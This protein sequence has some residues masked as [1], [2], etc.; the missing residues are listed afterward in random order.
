M[1]GPRHA[2]VPPEAIASEACSRAFSAVQAALCMLPAAA[3][4]RVRNCG[5]AR[6]PQPTPPVHCKTSVA[7]AACSA[8]HRDCTSP[9]LACWGSQDG[10]G[11]NVSVQR[12]SVGGAHPAHESLACKA[13]EISLDECIPCR[14]CELD[15]DGLAP[16]ITNLCKGERVIELQSL[17]IHECQV[18]IVSA[19]V[20]SSIQASFI[21]SNGSHFCID[22]TG[23]FHHIKS[24]KCYISADCVESRAG[25][26]AVFIAESS[27]RAP[28]R[29]GAMSSRLV[30][31][32]THPA[33]TGSES[34]SKAEARLSALAWALA[35]VLDCGMAGP[36]T[37]IQDAP[38]AIRAV[39]SESV[40]SG[41]SRSVTLASGLWQMVSAR[42]AHSHFVCA[43]SRL[44]PWMAAAAHLAY[45]ACLPQC[46]HFVTHNACE[47]A[48]SPKAPPL[49]CGMGQGRG[50]QQQE[51]AGPPQ[52][53]A[54]ASAARAGGQ[55]PTAASSASA[56]IPGSSGSAVSPFPLAHCAKA[57]PHRFRW[58]CLVAEGSLSPFAVSG[59]VLQASWSALLPPRAPDALA[60]QA[61]APERRKRRES[62]H[63]HLRLMQ[64]NVQSLGS[65]KAIGFVSKGKL[66]EKYLD[67]LFS[68]QGASFIGIQEA[69]TKGQQCRSMCHHFAVTS[70]CDDKCGFGCELWV[71]RTIPLPNGA[72]LSLEPK[73]VVVR[74]YSPRHLY[75]SV[76]CGPVNLDVVVCHGPC[77]YAPKPQIAGFWQGI[78]DLV[79]ESARVPVV[80]FA[81]ANAQVGPTEDHAIGDVSPSRFDFAG[82]CFAQC[83]HAC[84][85]M[86][87][88]TIR[89]FWKGDQTETW[90]SPAGPK[91]RIDYIALNAAD[92]FSDC[93]AWVDV[94]ADVTI[95]SRDHF[96]LIV[97]TCFSS[98]SAPPPTKRR[99]NICDRSALETPDNRKI[100]EAALQKIP[101]APWSSHAQDHHSDLFGCL[102]TIAVGV[103]PVSDKP[104][105]KQWISE[106]TMRVLDVRRSVRKTLRYAHMDAI[107][108]KLA[109]SML[110]WRNST[111]QLHLPQ[112]ER[113][114]KD[115]QL[116]PIV[117]AKRLLDFIQ[118]TMLKRLY[119]SEASIKKAIDNDKAN[120]LC[121]VAANAHKAMVSHDY[122]SLFAIMK[123][124]MPKQKKPVQMLRLPDQSLASTPDEIRRAWQSHFSQKLAGSTTSMSSLIEL[125][126]QQQRSS[127]L[128]SCETPVS[129]DFLPT[130]FDVASLARKL[131]KGKAAGEDSIPN[132]LLKAHPGQ[133]ARLLWPLMVKAIMKVQEPI[134]WKGGVLAEIFKG[135]GD[136]A[137]PSSY[138]GILVSDAAGKMLHSWHRRALL[139]FLEKGARQ[140]MCAGLHNKGT[141]HCAHL[142]RS[143]V[144]YTQACHISS[145]RLYIDI[146][147]AFDAVC[148]QLLWHEPDDSKIMYVLARMNISPEQIPSLVSFV[149]SASILS[150]M[151][152]PKHVILAVRDSHECSWFSTEGV[153]EIVNS[154][155]G[156]K[157][158]DPLGD[159]IFSF[160]ALSVLN[161]LESAL[162]DQG[163]LVKIP[164]PAQQDQCALRDPTAN[165]PL[166]EG[167]YVDDTVFFLTSPRPKQLVPRL[168][169]LATTVKSV[170]AKHAMVLNWKRGKSEAVVS[171]RGADA[172]SAYLDFV[173]VHSA[174]V[175]LQQDMLRAVAVYKHMGSQACVTNRMKAEVSS[176][177]GNMYAQY[178]PV[179]KSLY[180]NQDVPK[181]VRT[182]AVLSL[183]YTKLLFNAGMWDKL[184]QHSMRK[185]RHAYVT[186]LRAV[187][188]M[189][190]EGEKHYTSDQVCAAAQV[191][192][193]EKRLFVE[194][195]R[196]FVRFALHASD[197]HIRLVLHTTK[198]ESAWIVQI[199]SLLLF[200]W[201]NDPDCRG[202]PSPL[203]RVS[204]WIQ[205]VRDRPSEWKARVRRRAKHACMQCEALHD[206]HGYD[207]PSQFSDPDEQACSELAGSVRASHTLARPRH[208][209]AA[210]PEQEVQGQARGADPVHASPELASSLHPPAASPELEVP[211]QCSQSEAQ[212][213]SLQCLECNRF[214]GSRVALHSHFF[215]V[216]GVRNRL[217]YH[218]SGTICASCGTEF[219][220]R[221]RL[222]Q[223]VLYRVASCRRYYSEATEPM[224]PE[225]LQAIEEQARQVRSGGD[226][227]T[228]PL[229]AYKAY[230]V[231]S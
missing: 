132:E 32:P 165:P 204:R 86:A 226:A 72:T 21:G 208:P 173:I 55:A 171:F 103:A 194:R 206:A 35:F 102:R 33:F 7:L 17:N 218:I 181:E 5:L 145:A 107:R 139:P 51:G 59:S 40:R 16:I 202:L 155:S 31:D 189:T 65:S 229:P 162:G 219:H 193:I 220:Q 80:M 124:V 114:Q 150:K 177:C 25:W 217:N 187:M 118:A 111:K 151:G 39:A 29:I 161:E 24:I 88:S 147:G 53:R 19:A 99:S 131:S 227:K 77:S 157:P 15:P 156:S 46:Q 105:V 130:P 136:M 223:H 168:Q 137:A 70:G 78:Q 106:A 146:V 89:E 100:A 126:N 199:Q 169:M 1:S 84:N 163:L 158:G 231:V 152:V 44:S 196:Y 122:K 81:D 174:G 69:R 167:S 38:D 224:S 3:P 197:Q 11:R 104:R 116:D 82:K 135:S 93:K 160:A 64:F 195:L 141:D 47:M 75:A 18:P 10:R 34:V 121:E 22:Q 110:I 9:P 153:E 184:D 149:K 176:R 95:T 209:P 48:A 159:I 8:V 201:R 117:D 198:V 94:E 52:A 20:E 73:H 113:S 62:S 43:A 83:L 90:Q 63:V 60:P 225:E 186:P 228:L 138:R 190:F 175:P 115:Q 112:E 164:E 213:Q 58:A 97:D 13:R 61:K 134:P 178:R 154:R 214:F 191:A 182:M 180:A 68:E 28:L 36:F 144:A 4:A 79:M 128:Q 42:K 148:R 14:I 172:K 27:S 74:S 101:V 170:F 120:Y 140:N 26:A 30:T 85:L 23:K 66:R 119:L 92:S 108:L 98:K 127:F 45:N 216:H 71:A 183:L 133:A 54:R 185:I 67:Q 57:D 56:R 221:F 125:N 91:Y 188:D 192:P 230:S 49:A 12:W 207:F 109:A 215:R 142:S 37:F 76:R 96:P 222:V 211:G 166:M 205:D 2:A 143:F 87:P 6:S 210:S 50:G 129:V 179:R 200:V 41:R 123:Q 212:R 203:D